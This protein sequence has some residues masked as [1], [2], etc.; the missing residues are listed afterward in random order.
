MRDYTCIT[1][2]DCKITPHFAVGCTYEKRQLRA[3]AL[4]N[5][6]E[7]YNPHPGVYGSRLATRRHMPDFI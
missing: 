3:C 1:P 4:R 6:C 5:P 2:I 7:A